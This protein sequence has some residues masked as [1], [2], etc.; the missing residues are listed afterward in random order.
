MDRAVVAKIAKIKGLEKMPCDP[1]SQADLLRLARSQTNALLSNIQQKRRL[2][3]AVLVDSHGNHGDD[4]VVSE[5]QV[6]DGCR[7]MSSLPNAFTVPK[8]K[9]QIDVG[10]WRRRAPGVRTEE[11]KTQE[12]VS[13]DPPQR[14]FGFTKD[15]L[16]AG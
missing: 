15:S 8:Q 7:V 14:G 12:A 3:Q 1:P 11:D 9:H 2:A 5:G 4:C 10:T 6:C 13:V 16:E